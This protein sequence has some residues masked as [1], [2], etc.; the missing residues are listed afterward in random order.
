MVDKRNSDFMDLSRKLSFEAGGIAGEKG[1]EGESAADDPLYAGM[2]PNSVEGAGRTVYNVYESDV[3]FWLVSLLF[4][5]RQKHF[6][7]SGAWFSNECLL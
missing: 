4:H 2:D 1:E 6:W 7:A 3:L 5:G